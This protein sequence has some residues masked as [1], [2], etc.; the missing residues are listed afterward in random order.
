[1]TGFFEMPVKTLASKDLRVQKYNSRNVK[2]QHWKESEWEVVLVEPLCHTY[3][4]TP[5][6]S[7]AEWSS[8]LTVGSAWWHV[9]QQLTWHAH[10]V[11]N[12][13]AGTFPGFLH[14]T[15]ET[16]T[17]AFPCYLPHYLNLTVR[18][19]KPR[20]MAR[21]IFKKLYAPGWQPLF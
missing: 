2:A 14:K 9:S 15:K 1:M 17:C 8:R 3:L 19:S 11:P 20:D 16:E 13:I 5:T 10:C 12:G 21:Y 7:L 18:I 6:L 4:L